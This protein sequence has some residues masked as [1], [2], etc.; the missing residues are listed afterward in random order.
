MNAKDIIGDLELSA[1]DTKFLQQTQRLTEKWAAVQNSFDAVEPILRFM[2]NNPKVD[3]GTP[4]PLVHFVESFS[5]Q[6][7]EQKLIDSLTR[8]PT[9]HTVW[10]ANRVVNGSQDP[11]ERK[12]IADLLRK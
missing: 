1:R 5:G 12:R 10:M 9:T 4:G 6:G 7:Y 11:D 2:E 8:K 3:F